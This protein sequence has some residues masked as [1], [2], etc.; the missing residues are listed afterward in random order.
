MNKVIFRQALIL[1]VTLGGVLAMPAQ[2]TNLTDVFRVVERINKQAI[3]SQA[4]I[5]ALTDQTRQLFNE[6]KTVL[7]E[8]DGLK[9]YNQQLERQVLSQEKEM[10][11]LSSAI[12]KVTVIERQITPLMLRMIDGLEQFVNLDL[13]FLTGEREDRLNRLREMMDRADVAVSEK[14]SQIMRA[15]QIENDYGRTLEAYTDTIEVEGSERIVDVLKFGR[16]S[17][18]YQAQD[19]SETGMY[20]PETRQWQALDDSYTAGVRNG[21]RMARKQVSLDLMTI[22]VVGQ[23]SN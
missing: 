15:Y 22:P 4:K 13:P 11:D 19:G 16:L 1:A 5:D 3:S 12:D 2:A 20:N 8:I 9:V 23:G 17:L 21:I 18:M 6:Y 7:K 10:N 14:F